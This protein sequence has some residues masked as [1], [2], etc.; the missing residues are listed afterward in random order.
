MPMTTRHVWTWEQEKRAV[1]VQRD[2]EAIGGWSL[3]RGWLQRRPP[4]R[5]V[6]LAGDH[7]VYTERVLRFRQELARPEGPDE[8]EI[9]AVRA[10][11]SWVPLLPDRYEVRTR[12]CTY[13]VEQQGLLTTTRVRIFRDGLEIGRGRRIR[14]HSGHAAVELPDSVPVADAFMLLMTACVATAPSVGGGGDGGGGDG[15]G[16]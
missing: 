10:R 2:G 11:W 12:S 14:W 4:F 5:D 9:V 8:P 3:P 15:G 1:L 6:T 13:L 7:W 16:G